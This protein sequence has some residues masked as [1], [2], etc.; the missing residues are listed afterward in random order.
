MGS[1]VAKR[2]LE[3]L[4]MGSEGTGVRCEQDLLPALCVSLGNTR[5]LQ[6]QVKYTDI[7]C[8][9]MY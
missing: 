2:G 5:H 3:G 7:E 1:P 6:E 9:Q 4:K 8:V